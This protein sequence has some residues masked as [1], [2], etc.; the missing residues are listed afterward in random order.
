MCGSGGGGG[1]TANAANA[2]I[3]S[4]IAIVVVAAKL[5]L[6]DFPSAAYID[7]NESTTIH[8]DGSLDLLLAAFAAIC[9]L[10][11][12]YNVFCVLLY[13]CLCIFDVC[14]IRILYFYD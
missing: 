2:A 13:Y 9:H 4:N 10:S 5:L 12:Y 7:L 1:V 11:Y 8:S 14:Y 3:A 6:C